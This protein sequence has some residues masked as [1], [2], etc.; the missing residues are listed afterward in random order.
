MLLPRDSQPNSN[1]VPTTNHGQELPR[2]HRRAAV[3][4]VH[5]G[6]RPGHH[7]RAERVGTFPGY[8]TL[9][10]AGPGQ[11]LSSHAGF[12]YAEGQLKT[13]NVES[14]RGA[15][16]ALLEKYRAASAPLVHVVHKTP[17]GAPVFTPG[18]ALAAEFGELEPRGGE[19]VVGKQFPGSFTGTDLDEFLKGTGRGKVVLTG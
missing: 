8:H 10:D 9:A 13:A 7:R 5:Q 6:Q 3:D 11:G 2:T 17:E 19:K 4:G 16:A 14:T 1:Q 12:R 15:I 18:T